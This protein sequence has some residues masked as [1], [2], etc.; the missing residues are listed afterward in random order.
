MS[1]TF[2]IAAWVPSPPATIRVSTDPDACRTLRPA[3]IG[4][5]LEVMTGPA[6]GASTETS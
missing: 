5:P 1:R 4:S 6:S 3:T 2:S